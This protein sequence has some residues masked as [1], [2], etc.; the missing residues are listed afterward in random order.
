MC[1]LKIVAYCEKKFAKPSEACLVFPSRRVAEECRDFIRKQFPLQQ[2]VPTPPSQ[3]QL[4]IRIAELFVSPTHN[5]YSLQADDPSISISSSFCLYVVLFQSGA[6]S[7]A[8]QFWQHSGEGISSRFA[9]HCLK[10]L[11]ANER[12]IEFGAPMTGVRGRANV[13][14]R[15]GAYLPAEQERHLIAVEG[16]AVQSEQSLFVE[17]RFGRNLDVRQVEEA[18][19][20]LRKRIAGVLGDAD[21]E[22]ADG[23]TNYRQHIDQ[24]VELGDLSGRGILGISERDVFLFPT[25]MSAIYNA[26][27]I[28]QELRPDKKSVQYGFPYLDTLKIQEKFGPGC[29]F[30]GHGET[31]EIDYLENTILPSESI[32]AVFCEF[33]SN[34]LLRTPDLT[35]LRRLADKYGFLLVVDETVGNFVNVAAVNWADILVSSLTKIFSGD[36]NVMGGR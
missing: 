1:A 23:S 30:L 34:P 26:Y 16:E 24:Q 14:Y 21:I 29:H 28:V 4:V 19:I 25:G 11:G 13:R 36:S 7:V 12:S 15:K 5:P 32:S 31:D 18:K 17:E 2:N 35:R 3:Q 6:C 27:R 9:E 33:P 22:E 8:K 20:T 10:V